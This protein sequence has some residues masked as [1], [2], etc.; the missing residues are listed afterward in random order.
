MFD[1]AVELD[2][3]YPDNKEWDCPKKLFFQSWGDGSVVKNTD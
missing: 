1:F 2:C 3:W